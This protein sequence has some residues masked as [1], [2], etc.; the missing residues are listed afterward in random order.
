MSISTKRHPGFTLIELLVTI[1]IIGILTV[2]L[3]SNFANDQPRNA[4]KSAV[5]QLVSNL[6]SAQTAAQ[7]GIIPSGLS[8]T[9]AGYGVA[10]RTGVS[11]LGSCP[12]DRRYVVFANLPKVGA[13]QIFNCNPVNQ[14]QIIRTVSLPSDTVV[15]QLRDSAGRATPWLYVIFTYPT[16]T[17]SFSHQNGTFDDASPTAE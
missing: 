17:V 9:A 12:L 13:D 8:D 1:A 6:Q 4:I 15:I 2:I 11:E 16:G 14:D 3:F 7:S 10:F 5:T